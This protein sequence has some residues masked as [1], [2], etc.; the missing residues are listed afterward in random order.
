MTRRIK[1]AFGKPASWDQS[2][3]AQMARSTLGRMDRSDLRAL[4][5]KAVSSVIYI[6][7]YIQI[8]LFLII[9]Y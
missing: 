9:L 4:P 3:I 2:T 8:I 1:M 5:W 7:I 6:H